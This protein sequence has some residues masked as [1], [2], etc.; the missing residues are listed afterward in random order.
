MGR[1]VVAAI[2]AVTSR[3]RRSDDIRPLIE[4]ACELLGGLCATANRATPMQPLHGASWLCRE[5]LR[6]KTWVP[7]PVSRDIDL[8]E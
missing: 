5:D 6:P 2:N 7:T 3:S 1:D 8:A 4:D